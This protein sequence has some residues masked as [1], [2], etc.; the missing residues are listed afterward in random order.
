MPG[1]NLAMP[2]SLSEIE[3]SDLDFTDTVVMREA[4]TNERRTGRRLKQLDTIIDS[5]A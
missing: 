4:E 3:L 2:V 1:E 5:I